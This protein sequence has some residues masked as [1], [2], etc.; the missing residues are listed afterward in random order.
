MCD[1]CRGGNGPESCDEYLQPEHACTTM[2]SR[3]VRLPTQ[4]KQ[5]AHWVSC[6]GIHRF[7]SRA[8]GCLDGSN[9]EVS[10]TP[11][12][13]RL[14][15]ADVL[16]LRRSQVSV[17]ECD[18]TKLGQHWNYNSMSGLVKSNMGDC[19]TKVLLHKAPSATDVLQT[20]IL[21]FLVRCGLKLYLGAA[22]EH[23]ASGSTM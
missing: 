18:G 13:G 3:N 11:S 8:G 7:S 21:A 23:G 16:H 2:G 15:G 4:V 9:S 20:C 22:D 12:A 17:Q 6:R 14:A 5:A 10:P 1:S 19:L